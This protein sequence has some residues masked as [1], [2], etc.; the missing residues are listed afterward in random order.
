L[1]ATALQAFGNVC[2]NTASPANSFVLTGSNLTAADVVVGPLAAYSFSTTAAGTYTSSLTLPATGGSI[3][4]AVFVKFTPVAAQNYTGNIPVSGGGITS[5]VSVGAIG[6]GVNTAPSVTTGDSSGI[7][8]TSV[9]ASG[10]ITANG[11]SGVTEYGIEYS[12]INNFTGGSGTQ[13]TATGAGNGAFTVAIK[14]LVPETKYY[15]RAYA[16][17]GGGVSYGPVKSFTTGSLPDGFTVYPI[18][19]VRNSSLHF[20]F[21]GLKLGW[22]GIN[23]YNGAGQKVYTRGYSI[24]GNYLMESIRVPGSL[25]P[26]TYQLQLVDSNGTISVKTIVVF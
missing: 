21:K 16:R 12:G 13:V 11:C 25:Q 24:Q 4:Q 5:P 19:V 10:S 15:Y 14:G 23:L 26:G 22:Y 9:N 17:N 2:A 8:A 18:P 3:N 20:V 7:Q 1:V 6:L